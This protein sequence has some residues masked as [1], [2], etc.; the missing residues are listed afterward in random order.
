MFKGYITYFSIFWYIADLILLQNSDFH[1]ILKTLKYLEAWKRVLFLN[2]MTFSGFSRPYQTLAT[3]TR[4]RLHRHYCHDQG[5]N[6][7]DV[8]TTKTTPA[9]LNFMQSK[10]GN[11]DTFPPPPHISQSSSRHGDTA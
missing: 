3:L 8:L 2:S 1:D 9:V 4:L 11:R 6:T 7:V 5:M 10:T